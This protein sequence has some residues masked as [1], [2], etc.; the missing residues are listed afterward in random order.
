[1]SAKAERVLA[2]IEG[3]LDSMI[4]RACNRYAAM[5]TEESL[6]GKISVLEDDLI[7]YVD[8]DLATELTYELRNS[9]RHID[10]AAAAEIAEHAV[11]EG[12]I[13]VEK[14]AQ[15]LGLNEDDG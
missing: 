9:C 7:H 10:S 4:I 12:N 14:I 3:S 15:I 2:A 8:D 13:S 11:N 6:I 1:M 5:L